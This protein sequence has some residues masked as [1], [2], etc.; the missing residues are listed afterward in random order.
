MDY[1]RAGGVG[2]KN[3]FYEFPDYRLS[4]RES[5]EFP[6]AADAGNLCGAVRVPADRGASRRTSVTARRTRAATVDGRH[7]LAGDVHRHADAARARLYPR[8][9]TASSKPGR[10]RVPADIRR[11]DVFVKESLRRRSKSPSKLTPGNDDADKH[12]ADFLAAVAR[13]A[14]AIIDMAPLGTML[15]GSFL[16]GIEVGREAGIARNWCLF[17]GPNAAL[18]VDSVQAAA[19]RRTF[20]RHVDEGSRHPWTEDFPRLRRKLLADVTPGTMHQGW[21]NGRAPPELADHCT[22]PI[23]HLLA[24]E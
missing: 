14:P 20:A 23:P 13:Y 7:V 9:S 24:R 16:P 5:A 18:S 8:F 11:V 22:D 21:R 2:D 4:S 17:H 1:D 19:A 6:R 12:F 15:G 3:Q 10:R